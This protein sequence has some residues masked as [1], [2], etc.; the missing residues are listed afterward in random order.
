MAKIWE[1][2]DAKVAFKLGIAAFL[3]WT[4]GNWFTQTT[5]R[6]E[7]LISGVWCTVSAIVVLQVHLGGT[8][9]AA[10]HRFLGVFI[11][12]VIGSIFASFIYPNPIYLGFAVFLTAIT[13]SFF[14]IQETIRIA[15]LSVCVIMILWG[16]HSEST[17]WIFALFRFID[18]CIGILIG[19]LVAHLIWPFQAAR[20]LRLNMCHILFNL[21]H[22]YRVIID[23]SDW[24]NIKQDEYKSLANE[25]Y[26]GFKENQNYIQEAK[27]ELLLQPVRLDNWVLFEEYVQELFKLILSLQ[28]VYYRAKKIFDQ[29]LQEQLSSVIEQID[30]SLQQLSHKLSLRQSPGDLNKLENAIG[31]LQADL[32]RFRNTHTLRQFSLQD[33]ESYYVF[34]FTL[35]AIAENVQKMAVKINELYKEI[36]NGNEEIS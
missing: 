26:K 11:G 10:L 31:Q 23:A 20:K 3:G 5:N 27:I 1:K 34:F 12:S 15:C 16:F 28:G 9:H 24:N 33:A 32:V 36:N 4:I 29:S 35:N 17:P 22:L 14:R 2:F 21:S 18:S 6:A 8:Y 19:L 13:C 7:T 25:I 30:L